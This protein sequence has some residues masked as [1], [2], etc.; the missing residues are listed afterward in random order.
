VKHQGPLLIDLDTTS[1]PSERQ[2][3]ASNL[4]LLFWGTIYSASTESTSQL[5][6]IFVLSIF[7]S[8]PHCKRKFRLRF[9]ESA[10]ANRNQI[11]EANS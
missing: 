3:L 4:D 6:S 11:E 7:D 1:E 9:L 8:I 5:L 10:A 2:Q